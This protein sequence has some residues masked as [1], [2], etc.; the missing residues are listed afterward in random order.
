M[1]SV[2]GVDAAWTL[3]QP[4]GV[5]LAVEEL[6]GTWRVMAAAPSYRHFQS[7]PNGINEVGTRPQ[8][9]SIDVPALL[10]AARKIGGCS[11]TLVAIDM[12]LASTPISRRR[13][14]DNL[15]SQVYGGRKCGTHS[16]SSLRP[17]ALSDTLRKGFEQ[18]GYPLCTQSIRTPG[19]IEVYP[20]PALVELANAPQRL[21]YKVAKAKRYWPS[22]TPSERRSK[23]LEQWRSIVDLL[24]AEVSGVTHVLPP[25]EHTA[26]GVYCKAYEDILDAVVCA[27]VG[28][29]ALKGSAQPFG[30]HD[31]AIWIPRKSPSP[32]LSGDGEAR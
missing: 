11:I 30:D 31:S 16:P 12:P 3:T 19:L 21:P 26:S 9:S 8:G 6:A 2:L 32:S 28:V 13:V 22:A 4:S 7:L 25:L 18:S 23:L 15:I 1:R 17:G 27:W 14:S 24:E 20:H 10:D 29:C 5:A